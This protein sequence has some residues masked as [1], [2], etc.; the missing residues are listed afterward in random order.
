MLQKETRI[1]VADNSGAKIALIFGM[2]G[3]TGGRL[4]NIKVGDIVRVT[5]KKAVPFSEE[6]NK[7]PKVRKGEK[8][9]LMVVRTKYPIRRKNGQYI[10]FGENA[11]VLLN[12]NYNMIG[13]TVFGDVP[14]EIV[15]R[16]SHDGIKKILSVVSGGVL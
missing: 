5:I 11:G 13:T 14:K 8:Y 15:S 3:R 9:L 10:A 7:K 1:K 2:K 16:H 6:N 4:R 12:N